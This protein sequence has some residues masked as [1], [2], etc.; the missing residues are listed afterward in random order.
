MESKVLPMRKKYKIH[1]IEIALYFKWGDFTYS[2]KNEIFNEIWLKR[3]GLIFYS[4]QD[5]LQFKK[6]IDNALYF[7]E[8][9]DYEKEFADIKNI[10]QDTDNKYTEECMWDEYSDVESFFKL[11]KLKLTFTPNT[12]VVR[13]K[14]RKLLMELGY[15]KRSWQLVDKIKKSCKALG[16]STFVRGG[17]EC[18]I[19]KVDID[20]WISFRLTEYRKFNISSI[21]HFIR[22]K[23]HKVYHSK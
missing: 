3:E 15:Q 20:D 21:L 18:D 5:K 9:K 1:P 14:L 13:K 23:I 22:R 10:L 12:P 11:I 4:F 7:L 2:A 6:K 17:K 8:E 19:G 16:I